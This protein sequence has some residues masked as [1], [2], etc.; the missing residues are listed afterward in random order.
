MYTVAVPEDERTGTFLLRVNATDADTGSNKF[1]T[2]S[3]NAGDPSDRFYIHEDTGEL[4]LNA[5]LDRETVEKYRLTVR[6]T[7]KGGSFFNLSTRTEIVKQGYAV[8]IMTAS[9]LG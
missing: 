7:N 2:F 9:L 5:Q 4:F 1:F 3:I 6:A 8:G